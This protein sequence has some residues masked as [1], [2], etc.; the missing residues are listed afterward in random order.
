VTAVPLFIVLDAE[1]SRMPLSKLIEQQPSAGTYEL[2]LRAR[3]GHPPRT[4]MIEVRFAPLR[5]PLPDRTTPF[6]KQSGITD[7]PMW[8][9]EAREVNAPKN[10]EPL[11]WLLLTS[12]PV[13][14]FDDAWIVIGRYEKRP[15]VEDYHK[16][17]KTGC[18]VEQRQYQT[19]ERLERVT[20]LLSVVGVR[21][22]QLKFVARTDP[23]RPAA[24]VVPQ[25][26]LRMLKVIRKG[27]HQINTVS[28][29]FRSLAMLGGFL[30]RKSDG[31]PGW[32][33]IWRGLDKL[34]LCIRGADAMRGK[35]G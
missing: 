15:I 26:W 13:E 35:C 23:D 2:S 24:R 31:Q 14:K 22:L 20:G 19:S 34:L 8:A 30:G 10:V 1:G 32:I 27:R 3:K 12:E 5:M 21:L 9:V 17:I 25:P 28:E 7:I 6:M 33:T 16:C 4:A 18:R 29:F 11:N